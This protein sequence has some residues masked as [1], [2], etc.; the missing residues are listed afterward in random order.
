MS[1]HFVRLKPQTMTGR[2]TFIRSGIFV[3]ILAISGLVA[4]VN[5]V[6]GSAFFFLAILLLVWFGFKKHQGRN[7]FLLG[8]FHFLAAFLIINAIVFIP[9]LR[10]F[11]TD[12]VAGPLTLGN[13]LLILLI[14]AGGAI[15]LVGVPFVLIIAA[16]SI[17]VSKW[18][19]GPHYRAY[20]YAFIHTLFSVLGIGHFMVVVDSSGNLKGNEDDIERLESFGGPGWLVVHI[21][22][23]V[24]LQRQGLITRAVGAGSWMLG[25]QEQIKAILPLLPA[26]NV[27]PLENVLTRDRIPL[28][29]K[30]L[31]AAQIEPAE[32]T[33]ARFQ[34]AVTDAEKAHSQLK[35]TGAAQEEI[36]AAEES[37]NSAKKEL[38]ELE[39]EPTV[40]DDYNKIYKRTA[41]LAARRATD[42]WGSVKFPLA[43]TVKDAIMAVD[44]EDLFKIEGEGADLAAKINERKIAELE[45]YLTDKTKGSALGKGVKLLVVDLNEITFPDEIKKKIE[46]EVNTLIEA[47]IEETNARIA[48]SKAKATIIAAR[49]KAQ[50]R[51][52]DGQGEG[53]ARA[54]L[55]REL[56]RELKQDGALKPEQISSATLG[57]ISAMTSA[58][59]M[60]G[61][62]RTS[63]LYPR[64]PIR[65][66][67]EANGNG[68]LHD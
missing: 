33:L 4:S 52:I 40:G 32:D 42:V 63:A 29:I 67:E 22:Q 15:L 64:I 30:V 35:T 11:V 59:E 13:A 1:A 60:E 3:A 58:K 34:Q 20:S 47:R 37:L 68:A 36:K 7:L 31:H 21:G 8:Y 43:S 18:H 5:Y 6:M 56:L 57:L 54:A 24:V 19:T 44:A 16:A 9:A 53:E 49:A 55:F 65:H 66:G 48:E 23:V 38:A 28:D 17:V 2:G 50:A 39:K 26:G 41:I 27:N 25:R 45:K 62:V 46:K 61:L 51:I 12:T 10:E 14:S